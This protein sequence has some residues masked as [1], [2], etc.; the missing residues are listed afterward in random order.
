MKEYFS[1]ADF[2]AWNQ[3]GDDATQLERC[4]HFMSYY[5]GITIDELRA[6]PKGEVLNEYGKLSEVFANTAAP[7][8]YPLIMI[9][10]VLH[11]YIDISKMSLG[12]YVDLEKMTKDTQ[13][14]LPLI[15]ALLYRPIKKHQL[16]S[17]KYKV[18]NGYNVGRKQLTNLWDY[19]ELEP[20][21]YSTAITNSERMNGL[22]VAFAMGALSFFLLQ[23]SLMQASMQRYSLAKGVRERVKVMKDIPSQMKS[24]MNEATVTIGSGLQL[25]ATSRQLPSLAS[26]G[27]SV[28]QI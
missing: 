23:T 22:P 25:F 10:D 19:Y 20:Y 17:L 1:I 16:N 2:N 9:D 7:Q 26:Q 11:G 8:F 14:N 4:E 27:I 12:E 13:Q 6:L 21:N 5:K 15:T 3:L 28:L 24:M 18:V